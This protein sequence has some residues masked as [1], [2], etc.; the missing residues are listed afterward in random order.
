ML[1][2]LAGI[3]LLAWLYLVDMALGTDAGAAMETQAWTA[4]YAAMMFAMWVIMMVGMML[5]AAAPVMLLHA[6]VC[7]RRI[8]RVAPTAWFLL[9]YI[10]AWTLYSAGATG[11]QWLLDRFALLSPMMTTTS[12]W[13]GGAVV[14]AAGVYQLTSYKN[15]CLTHCRSPMDFLA[16]RWRDGAGGALRMG[17]EHGAF[18]VGCCWVLMLILFVVGV[19]D[20]LWIALLALFV[21]VEKLTPFGRGIGWVTGVGLVAGGLAMVVGG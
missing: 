7:R 3:T 18:C 21:F 15:A 20:L 4:R 12:A 6:R 16:R 11:L 14:V 5:P 2:A 19:M 1:G 10:I 13:L 9:G 8:D 17:M